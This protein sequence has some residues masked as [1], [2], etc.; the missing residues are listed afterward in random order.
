MRIMLYIVSLGG[1][2]GGKGVDASDS[3]S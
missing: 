1:G 2:R 3:T